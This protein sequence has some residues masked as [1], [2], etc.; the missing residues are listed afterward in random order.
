MS[1]HHLNHVC[2]PMDDCWMV[3]ERM[4]KQIP[5]SIYPVHRNLGVGSTPEMAIRN[6][7][8]PNWDIEV[9]SDE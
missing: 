6:S 7:V 4:G 9:I 1:D 2:I 8:V 3:F 5:F